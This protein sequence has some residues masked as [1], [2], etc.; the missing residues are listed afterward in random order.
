MHD[1]ALVLLA[2]TISAYWV[3][4]GRM[5]VRTRRSERTIERRPARAR[6][7]LWLVWVPLIAAWIALP[8]LALAVREGF[9]AV[10]AFATPGTDYGVV[11]WT[12]ALLG[13][14]SLGATIGCWRKMGRSWRMDVSADTSTALIT[15]GPY[16]TIRHP[17]YAWAI[18]L[19]VCS[20]AVVPNVP[21]FAVAIVHIALMNQKARSE[22]RHLE[23]RHG[24]AWRRYAA[25]TGR[26][27][28]RLGTRS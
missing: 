16:R 10:P 5:I 14:V 22:E 11:R 9:F 6:R 19:M 8:W 27:L 7:A 2:V 12:A 25:R 1:P 3:G 4:V 15:D 24:D 28:P 13:V 20:A 18:V 23:A 21:M 26:F 17:I